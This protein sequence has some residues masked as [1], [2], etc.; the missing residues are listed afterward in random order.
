M[1]VSFDVPSRYLHYGTTLAACVVI[2]SWLL[3]K[4]SSSLEY[5]PSPP[6]DPILGHLRI[7]PETFH[8]IKFSEWATKFGLSFV[9]GDAMNISKN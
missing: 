1:P 8:W 9:L 6:S 2:G 7:M 5:F 4:R 3:R